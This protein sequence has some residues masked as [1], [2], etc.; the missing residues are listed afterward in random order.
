MLKGENMFVQT[1]KSL[2]SDEIEE[3]LEWP[4]LT[5]CKNPFDRNTEK[6]SEYLN[7]GLGNNFTNETEYQTIFQG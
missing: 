4:G 2:N 1:T 6:L 3:P 7:K 5:I